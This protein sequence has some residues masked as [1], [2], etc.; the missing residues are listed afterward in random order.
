MRSVARFLY[1]CTTCTFCRLTNAIQSDTMKNFTSSCSHYVGV[2]NSLHVCLPAT[3]SVLTIVARVAAC[4]RTSL[5]TVIACSHRR[6]GQDKTVLSCL[7]RVG[8]VNWIGDK[9]RQFC[10]VSKCGLNRVLSCLD[11]VS[12]FQLFSI[13]YIEDYW[14]LSWL[15]ASSVHST[16]TDKT[17]Q[18]CPVRVGDVN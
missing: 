3:K 6:H 18:F 13:K 2:I 8:G 14:K 17:R 11:P 4:V 9:T 12:N 15:V 1:S 5:I 10:P 7:V 16:D